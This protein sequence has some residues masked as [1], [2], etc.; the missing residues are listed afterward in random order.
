[1]L[2]GERGFWLAEYLDPA[3]PPPGYGQFAHVR[4][5]VLERRAGSVTRQFA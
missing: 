3:D 2:H 4:L 5:D 1:L